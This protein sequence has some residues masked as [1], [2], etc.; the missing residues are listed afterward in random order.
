VTSEEELLA[1]LGTPICEFCGG[2]KRGPE[3]NSFLNILDLNGNQVSG[4]PC[5]KICEDLA[6]NR[7]RTRLR[8]IEDQMVRDAEMSRDIYESQ[9]KSLYG[10]SSE[11]YRRAQHDHGDDLNE[12]MNSWAMGNGL[13]GPISD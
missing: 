5:S 9:L 3:R 11:E 13:F 1:R 6:L 4:S 8:R 7:H 10:S 12:A 2:L